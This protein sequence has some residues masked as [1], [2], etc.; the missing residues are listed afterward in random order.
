M[1]KVW[2]KRKDAYIDEIEIKDHS[3]YAKSGQDLVCAG[4]SSIGIGMLNAL[5]QLVPD[6][7]ELQIDEAYIKIKTKQSDERVQLLLKAMLI[8]L[9][10]MQESYQTYIT[11]NDQEV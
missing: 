6:M 4:V 10:T 7:C 5:D 9:S 2:V 8:Q 1:V 11:I 3:G